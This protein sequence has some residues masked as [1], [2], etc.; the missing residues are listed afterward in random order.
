MLHAVQLSP[1]ALTQ[2]L[3]PDEW[4]RLFTA[5]RNTLTLWIDRLRSE[6]DKGFLRRR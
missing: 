6:G 3:K 4:E 5:T 2:K 1:I